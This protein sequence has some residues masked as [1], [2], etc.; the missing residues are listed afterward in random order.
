[1]F[2][3]YS[4]L[5]ENVNGILSE[6]KEFTKT[7]PLPLDTRIRFV[8]LKKTFA[9]YNR[10]IASVI[11]DVSESYDGEEADEMIQSYLKKEAEI[12][13]EPFLVSELERESEEL[14]TYDEHFD[15]LYLYGIIKK[16]NE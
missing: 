4:I 8:E 12:D 9:D 6:M 16:D 2:E 13:F 3:A 1:M 11:Q 15:N 10:Q 5:N 7:Q 14:I